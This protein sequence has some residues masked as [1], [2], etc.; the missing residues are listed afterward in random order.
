M[1]FNYFLS[2]WDGVRLVRWS[3]ITRI[4]IIV[5]NL[6]MT[7]RNRFRNLHS[8]SNIILWTAIWLKKK[9]KTT[10]LHNKNWFFLCTNEKSFN[11]LENSRVRNKLIRFSPPFVRVW[12]DTYVL[13]RGNWSELLVC[14]VCTAVGAVIFHNNSY[15]MRMFK[16][17]VY[18]YFLLELIQ[19][20]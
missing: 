18:R 9:K 1:F 10:L 19:Y 8:G 5:C 6:K 20:I 2:F 14:C 11:P 12:A 13:F 3:N 17:N 7:I 4:M 16:K 15:K